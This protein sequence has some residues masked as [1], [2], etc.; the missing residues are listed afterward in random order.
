MTVIRAALRGRTKAAKRNPGCGEQPGLGLGGYGCFAA[1]G[2]AAIQGYHGR[3]SQQQQCFSLA[4]G[5]NSPER[6]CTAHVRLSRLKVY[7]SDFVDREEKTWSTA[8][9]EHNKRR[10]SD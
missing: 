2:V 9:S 6:L 7:R 5:T 3:L 8:G 4:E 1:L 10:D